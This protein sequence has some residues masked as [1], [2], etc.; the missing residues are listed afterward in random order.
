MKAKGTALLAAA[1]LLA[2]GL[3]SG[4]H[5][6]EEVSGEMRVSPRDA[7]PDPLSEAELRKFAESVRRVDGEAEAHYQLALYFQQHYRHQ[8]AIDELKQSLL[9]SPGNPKAY[10]ALGVSFDNLGDHEAAID[11]Y[12]IA[13]KIDPTLDYVYNNLGYSHLLRGD[14]RQAIEAFEQAIAKNGGERRYRNNLGLAL[15]KQGRYEEAF[16]Q[17][18]A[19]DSRENAEKRLARVVADLGRPAEAGRVIAALREKPLP[20]QASPVALE[21][22]SLPELLP[23][24]PAESPA[25]DPV[26]RF[27]TLRQDLGG[28]GSASPAEARPQGIEVIPATALVEPKADPGPAVAAGA[29][30]KTYA[31]S[32][33]AG[34]PEKSGKPPAAAIGYD[35]KPVAREL[36]ALA[37]PRAELASRVNREDYEE[38]ILVAA[39]TAQAGWQVAPEPR[40]T[41]EKGI[42]EV[43]VAN[44][45]GVKG[46]ASR[47]AAHLKRLGFRVVRVMDANSFDHYHTKVFYYG[48]NLEEARRVL[49]AL[50]EIADTAEL[51]EL[52]AAAGHI[53]L[54]VGHDLVEKNAGLVWNRAA[55][56]KK[57]AGE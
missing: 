16:E 35:P 57:G 1:V 32:A 53:R 54:L 44:G 9:R 12:R 40:R 24:G 15:A 47:V 49:A 10:N 22:P 19:L 29:E 2:A 25:V 26:A 21:K 33:L 14:I 36:R 30:E 41:A 52:E 13:L 23:R 42:V 18:A 4:C 45:N 39:S 28:A 55:K 50:P 27:R 11:Y 51:Y 56:S 6:R 48:E 20:G 3:L 5:T 37:P 8:L 7:R 34:A 17:F 31:V 46:A 43:E 38:R